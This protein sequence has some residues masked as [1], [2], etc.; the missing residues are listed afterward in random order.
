MLTDQQIAD[1]L[2]A[3]DDQ[4]QVV[5]SRERISD[6]WHISVNLEPRLCPGEVAV[7]ARERDHW[8]VEDVRSILNQHERRSWNPVPYIMPYI[9]DAK[10]VPNV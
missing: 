4:Q 3:L 6:P 5:V 2:N 8:E 10:N 1:R 9:I 7:W